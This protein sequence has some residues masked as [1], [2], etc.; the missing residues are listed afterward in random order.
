[1]SDSIQLYLDS[2]FPQRIT[3]LFRLNHNTM[4]LFRPTAT[5]CRS[6]LLI[7][8]VVFGEQY[9]A[10]QGASE[11]DQNWKPEEGKYY[12]SEAWVWNFDDEFSD[13]KGE[14][15][16]YVDTLSGTFLFN[17]DSYGSSD[18]QADFIIGTRDGVYFTGITDENGKKSL[19]IDTL[20]TTVDMH[21]GKQYYDEDFKKYTKPTGEFKI[22]GQNSKKWSII[23]GEKYRT[24]FEMPVS[25]SDNYLIQKSF[26][27]LP[28]YNFNQRQ[29][30]A[31]LPYTF[32]LGLHMNYLLV[33]TLYETDGKKLFV[34]LNNVIPSK[35][36]IDFALYKK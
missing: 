34:I 29:V 33:E 15:T 14:I 3:F 8:I 30:S 35:Q 25:F 20:E 9:A 5:L 27:L 31:K 2:V 13:T 18:D 21:N 36:V 1:M 19:T 16:V 4:I 17:H 6:I 22:Y 10:A 26:S 11:R 28:I 23:K 24:T 32:S 12:F 7:G